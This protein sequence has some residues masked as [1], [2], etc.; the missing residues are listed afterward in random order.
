MAAH[1]RSARTQIKGLAFMDGPGRLIQLKRKPLLT[2]VWAAG[3]FFAQIND[4]LSSTD[5]ASFISTR[6]MDTTDLPLI[7]NWHSYRQA[8]RSAQRVSVF[9]AKSSHFSLFL[10]L[11]RGNKKTTIESREASRRDSF[12]FFVRQGL[13]NYAT[14][15]FPVTL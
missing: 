7:M 2:D 12:Y 10:V 5:V 6:V 1:S 4:S 3:G 8:V 15:F 14:T 9:S 13:G 11:K